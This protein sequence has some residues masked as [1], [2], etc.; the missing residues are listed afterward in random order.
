SVVRGVEDALQR[1]IRDRVG[2]KRAHVAPLFDRAIHRLALITGK[3]L[4]HPSPPRLMV[5]TFLASSV[6]GSH[7][8]KGRG[9]ESHVT[10]PRK[11]AARVVSNPGRSPA[12]RADCNRWPHHV[13]AA[14]VPPQ[15]WGEA[16]RPAGESPL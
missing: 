2:A 4:G 8:R 9:A 10:M 14:A 3:L 11:K 12:H 16:G 5:V 15:S 7:I 13:R 1:G 6:D